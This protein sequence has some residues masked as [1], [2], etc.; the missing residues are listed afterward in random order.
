MSVQELK[1]LQQEEGV[2]KAAPFMTSY[3]KVRVK[4]QDAKSLIWGIDQDKLRYNFFG[5]GT[6]PSYR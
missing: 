3:S 5:T 2:A 1:L 4:Q 6:W